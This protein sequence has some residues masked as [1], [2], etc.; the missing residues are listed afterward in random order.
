VAPS[1]SPRRVG[2]DLPPAPR[3][4]DQTWRWFQTR[5][6]PRYAE[7]EPGEP[8]GPIVEWLGSSTDIDD[9]KRLQTRQAA[10]ISELEHRTESLKN[11]VR[12]LGGAVRG[13]AAG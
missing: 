10:L 13:S 8:D 6:L 12:S 2:R 5:S 7:P 11:V 4:S 3:A 1:S 9:L